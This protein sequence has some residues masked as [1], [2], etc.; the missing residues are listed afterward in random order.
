ML[1][2]V[3]V[4]TL[5]GKPGEGSLVIMLS[6]VLGLVAIHLALRER[7][8]EPVSPASV[9]ATRAGADHLES[10]IEHLQDLK[11]EL[12]DNEARYRELL[13]SL[14]DMIVRRGST[15]EL[16]FVNRAFCLFFKVEPADVVGRPWTPPVLE[17]D[18]ESAPDAASGARHRRHCQLLAAGETVRWIEWHEHLIPVAGSTACEVQ[19][20]GRDVT[21]RRRHESELRQ[22]RDA[23]EAANRAKSRFL[24]AMSHEIR[25]PMNGILGM[26]SLIEDT[27]LTPEQAT[28]TR[29]IDQSARNLL[30]LIDEIL[31]FSKIE[32]GKLSI[33][34]DPFPV[35]Q[36]LQS[37]VELLAPR[38]HEKRLEIA[39]HVDPAVPEI[40]I[41]DCARVRQILLNLV[42]NA[43]K[44]TDVGGVKVSVA[45]AAGPG[46]G[47][48]FAVEDTGIGLSDA[49][50][51]G[52]FAE[53]EQSEAAIARREGGTGL[54]LAI[55]KRLARAMGGD[56]T[57][58]SQLGH[59]S[60]FRL[61]LPVGVPAAAERDQRT[62]EAAD[63]GS[64]GLRVLLAFDR[65]MERASLVATL[66]AARFDV[67]ETE[68]AKAFAA[69]EAAA[70]AGRP[71][72]RI[73]VDGAGDP[74]RLGELLARARALNP[75]RRVRGIVLVNL[76]SRSGLA[77][78]RSQ[79]FDAYLMRPVRP[80]SLLEQLQRTERSGEAAIAAAR[81]ESGNR[82]AGPAPCGPRILLA[83]DNAVNALL[84]TRVLEKDGYQVTHVRTGKA[85][86]GA[87]R[88][89][90]DA[91]GARFDLILMDIFMPEMDGVEAARE[92]RAIPQ[93]QPCPP[94]VALTANAF[95]EARQHYL[96]A[97]LDDYLA[98]PFDRQAISAIAARWAPH[99]AGTKSSSRPAA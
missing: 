44:F 34:R 26:A 76:L 63:A 87:V 56:V 39:W 31:D 69:V 71:F 85:A 81:P 46:V 98:K 66:K 49:D 17:A 60:V 41:G 95:A 73:I 5:A 92:I 99:A 18:G 21:G 11:W 7:A 25:T 27:E 48:E 96:K 58:R 13:D 24:A 28:Y 68:A 47:L 97:G 12:R 79:G 38:A 37:T 45:P 6:A 30:T 91:G 3:S 62:E 29:A 8:S 50:M 23:A 84:A 88:Q 36:L 80:Q 59:G 35:V 82:A 51:A 22:A 86:V 78:L 75:S 55:S 52:L 32:A 2:I 9:A 53:F 42:S 67:A 83:E 57:A 14:D 93:L 16:T 72:D 70:E 4:A 19:S 10:R 43:V 20:T 15:G 40:V 65:A 64:P 74:A 61:E 94:I 1:S 33:V 54:G 90:L 77:P 89:S